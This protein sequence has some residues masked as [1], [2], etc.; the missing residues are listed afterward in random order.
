MNRP[1][2]RPIALAVACALAL[3]SARA[4]AAATATVDIDLGK[5]G[6]PVPPMFYGLMTEEINHAYDG[7][8][9]AELIQNRTFQDDDQRPAHWS[10][11]GGGTLQLDRADPVNWANPVSLRVTLT[12]NGAAG[13]A[14]DGFW[15]IPVKAETKYAVSFYAK[16]GDGFAGPV[17]AAIVGP[18]A[19]T[20]PAASARARIS[21]GRHFRMMRTSYIDA[22]RPADCLCTVP[23]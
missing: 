16:G 22:L 7:G 12:G 4:N 21:G 6:T 23:G 11:V 20:E 13:A 15:G 9:Y 18:A 1:F 8:L 10:A 2:H 14:N 17:T 3:A 19:R 5:P